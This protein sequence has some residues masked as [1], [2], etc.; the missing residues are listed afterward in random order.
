MKT[1]NNF[2]ATRPFVVKTVE[3]KIKSG[4]ATSN[5]KTS[6]QP[7]EVVFECHDFPEIKP[8]DTVYVRADMFA[9]Q[10]AKEEFTD[11]AGNPYILVPKQFVYGY[12]S[13]G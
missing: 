4:F 8:G 6:L 12:K 7:L 1:Y 10:W 5:Q 13:A 11:G 3:T 9:H 2:V